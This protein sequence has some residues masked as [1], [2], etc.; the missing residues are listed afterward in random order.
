VQEEAAMT[1][2]VSLIQT[3]L[4]ELPQQGVKAD[5]KIHEPTYAL[6]VRGTDAQIAA[7]AQTFRAFSADAGGGTTG[8]GSSSAPAPVKS[9][10]P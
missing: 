5:L 7:V 4:D 8:G 1:N 9:P 6:I 3:V 2:I 10:T